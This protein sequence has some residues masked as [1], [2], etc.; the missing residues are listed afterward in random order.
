M[1]CCSTGEWTRMHQRSV[2]CCIGRIQQSAMHCS[3]VQWHAIMKETEGTAAQC[4][5]CAVQCDCAVY[6]LQ[7]VVQCSVTVQCMQCRWMSCSLGSESKRASLQIDPLTSAVI[8]TISRLLVMVHTW[9][10][11]VDDWDISKWGRRVGFT[12]LHVTSQNPLLS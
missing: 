4:A 1:Q 7:C 3:R 10:A 11:N 9:W 2:Q 12:Q 8:I 6:A 5:V